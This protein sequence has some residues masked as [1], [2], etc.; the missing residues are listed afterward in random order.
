VGLLVGFVLTPARRHLVTK[1]VAVGLALGAALALPNLVWQVQHGWPTLEFLRH[2]HADK[3]SGIRVMAFARAQ[4]G[5]LH[6]FGALVAA[7]GFWDLLARLRP[8]GIAAVTVLLLLVIGGSK[9]YYFVSIV[10]LLLAAG[11]ARVET[12]TARR[13]SLARW[14]VRGSLTLAAT[15]T[16]IAFLPTAL[17][18]LAPDTLAAYL[19]KIEG[20]GAFRDEDSH[21]V[22]RLPQDYASMMGWDDFVGTVATVYAELPA[23]ERPVAGVLTDNWTKA[24]AID[25]LGPRKGLPPA[26]SGNNNYYLWGPTPTAPTVI[27]AVG[28]D[29]E[30]LTPFFEEVVERARVV[31]EYAREY[32]VPVT[33][34][35]KP[36]RPFA[37][38]FP[39]FRHYD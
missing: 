23:E 5:N 20:E 32:D 37:S 3:M 18:V 31:S 4:V 2:A 1:R 13:S 6:L 27:V 30:E 24:G 39:S 19:H 16:G 17:P 15:A 36:R 29:V 12:L 33:I 35:R 14:A 25:L 21:R 11:S 7:L 22:L 8:L 28:F 9:P 34:C 38:M 26:M 10:P